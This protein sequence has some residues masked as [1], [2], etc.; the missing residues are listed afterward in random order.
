MYSPSINL[1]RKS[2][3]LMNFSNAGGSFARSPAKK[4]VASPSSAGPSSSSGMALS[5]SWFSGES[6]AAAAAYSN[7]GPSRSKASVITVKSCGVGFGGCGCG[8]GSG[9]GEG[10]GKGL[11]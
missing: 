3:L 5:R 6:F 7:G 10:K 1:R 11:G 9:T 2:G 4:D 8:C